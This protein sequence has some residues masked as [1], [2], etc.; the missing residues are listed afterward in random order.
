MYKK[1]LFIIL[2]LLV[3]LS[4]FSQDINRLKSRMGG[5]GGG[6]SKGK[7]DSL[8]HRDPNADS[9]T[10]SYRFF[11]ST[12]I[13]HIDS[14]IN[15]WYS[16]FPVPPTYDYLSNLGSAAHSLLF[17][18]NMQPGFDAGFHSY[19]IYRYTL[20]GTKFYQ[21]TRP[22]TELAYMV[23]SKTEQ[24]VNV[25][26]TQ[27][28]KN[29][30]NFSFEYRLIASPGSFRN[31]NTSHNNFRIS[32]YYQS[33]NKRYGLY[34]IYL[35]NKLKASENGGLVADSSLRNLT[36][37][38]PSE[39]AIKLG[40]AL[41]AA[42][43]G[44][45]FN[46]N[47]NIGTYYRESILY[48]RQYYDFGQKDSI[49]HDS[50]VTRL[51]YPRL[52]L[53]HSISY[54]SNLYQYRDVSLD[55]NSYIDYFHYY[56]ANGKDS[57]LFRD[58]WKDFTNEFSIITFPDKKNV[59]QFFRLSADLQLLNGTFSNGDTKQYTNVF[60]SAEYRNR[61]KNGKWDVEAFGQ[62]YL[63]GGFIG[64]YTANVSL[65]RQLG[66]KLGIL[67]IG[68]QN[69][70]KSPTQIS[71]NNTS[72]PVIP[73]GSFNNTNIAKLFANYFL[74]QTGLHLYGNYYGI[75]NYTYF[76]SYFTLQQHAP[77]FNYLN[78]GLDK[79]VR[80][81]RHLNWY[82]EAAFQQVAGNAPVHLPQ[83]Y[84]RNR[85]AFEGN[86]YKNLFLSLGIEVRYFTPYKA[87]GYS[88]LNGQFYYQTDSTLSNRPDVNVYFN[89]RI[90]SFKAFVRL[91]NLN[92]IDK[93]N[94]TY[95]FI[96]HN[97]SAPHYAQNALWLRFGIWWN[98]VN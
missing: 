15:D 65:Q 97:F 88:P 41:P 13:R 66:Q 26:H 27:N 83:V 37:N 24:M 61:T 81:S 33:H 36:L 82:T 79:K 23:G 35:N 42:A 87:D 21:T 3:S 73:V 91:E 94:G 39:A 86:F 20:P 57:L 78:V 77:L 48:L 32:T 16:R 22:Y 8:V 56:G 98:F 11:D 10:I 46:S 54:A 18:P 69:T 38:D 14:S 75:T 71:D 43:L 84:T 28:R 67:Q 40:N 9:I 6:S 70:N 19:D 60:A 96:D 63:A 85:V 31:Q 12:R 76:D 45:A 95:G 47:V 34:F 64:N 62:L 17:N 92:T 4:L 7:G 89:F 49:V 2:P 30:L 90:K 80:L 55:S 53:Q 52:R 59:A 44:N 58:K 74:P 72:F 25:L 5:F 68:F 29:N 51:F 93:A 1:A 50:T